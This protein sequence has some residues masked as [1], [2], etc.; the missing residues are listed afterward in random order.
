[1]FFSLLCQYLSCLDMK[2]SLQLNRWS[3]P[4]DGIYSSRFSHTLH[5]NFYLPL[6]AWHNLGSAFFLSSI[7]AP[8]TLGYSFPPAGA[9]YGPK[10]EGRGS[11]EHGCGVTVPLPVLDGWCECVP[12]I[13]CS[14]DRRR[15]LANESAAVTKIAKPIAD[16]LPTI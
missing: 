14:D 12:F 6:N 4:L 13:N 8:S 3:S 5:K 7:S 15:T 16:C 2:L 9:M 1:M 10:P 11:L